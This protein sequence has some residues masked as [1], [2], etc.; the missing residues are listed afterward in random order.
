MQRPLDGG[1]ELL[2]P[3]GKREPPL[4]L[5]VGRLHDE[6]EAELGGCGL[7]LLAAGRDGVSGEG[8]TG[9]GEALALLQLRDGELGALHAERMGQTELGRDARGDRNRPVD[10]GCDHA[11]DLLG[12]G[13]SLERR[14]VLGRDQCTPVGEREAGRSG[15]AVGGDH[16]ELPPA[17]RFEQTELSGPGAKHE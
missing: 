6:R 3:A 8:K 17:R 11:V 10:P 2:E 12:R 5:A 15:I 14:L 9:L 4:P 1:P 13:E 16:V 7:G